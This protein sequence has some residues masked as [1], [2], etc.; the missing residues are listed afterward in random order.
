MAEE[1]SPSKVKFMC[2]F[3]G[4]IL[5]RPS[6]GVLKYVGGET[7]VVAVSPDIS[8]SELMKKLTAITENDIVLK[9]QIIPEDLDALVSVKSDED[10]KHMIEEYNRHET[11]KLR[12]F[13]FP[14]NPVV[15]ES[16]LG[17]I[18]PQTIEQRYIEAINGILRTSKSATALRAP[19]KTRPSFTVST[20][21]S[22]KSESPDGYSHEP[23]ET[24]F[25]NNYQLSRLYP[26][27]RV[28]S[29]PNISHQLQPHS[30]YH[31]HNHNAY[32]QPP[33]NYLTCRPR[34]PTPLEI[35]RGIG[36]DQSYTTTH[37]SGGGNGKYGC[38]DDRRFW[39]R[40]SSVPQSPRNHGLRL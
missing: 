20:C 30:H 40:A 35:P 27:H 8:F 29:S 33:T 17:P 26:M 24:S 34:L 2:S 14:A 3:G 38:N 37:N 16:Q 15:L 12:T 31:N 21:S 22:P 25:Q 36:W 11:P 6:D 18:E 9:Y 1:R 32:V 4:R 7:R 28:H 13:L 5:P 39:G 10:V 19:I 23:P